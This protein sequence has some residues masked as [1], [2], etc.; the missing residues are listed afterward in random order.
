M[1]GIARDITEIKVAEQRVEHLAYYDG[2]TDLPN[3]TLL[4]QRAKLALALAAR[5]QR[6]LT[7]LFLDLEDVYKRQ[8]FNPTKS[9]WSAPSTMSP[10]RRTS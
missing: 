6:E 1:F 5:Y 4:A 3:R 10:A 7:V 2:L 8:V 9:D